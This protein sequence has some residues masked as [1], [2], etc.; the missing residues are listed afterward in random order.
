[1]MSRVLPLVIALSV[2]CQTLVAQNWDAR[3]LQRVNGWDTQFANKYNE[4]MSHSIYAVGTAV[5]VAIGLASLIKRD[6]ELM[7]D[8]IYIGTTMAEAAVLTFSAKEI[9]GRERPFDRWPGMIVQREQVGSYSFPSGHTAMAFS[10]ATSLSLRYPKWYV[11]VPSALWATSVGISRMQ[12]GVHYPS[13]VISGALIGVG[14][15]FVNVYVNK[16]LDRLIFP[17]KRKPRF[18]T[19]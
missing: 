4:V 8:A 16:W 14:V 2:M 17:E 6:R 3:A 5:P 9:V 10:L 7:A 18:F 11:I 1:M 12:R 13:D 15:A 19:R